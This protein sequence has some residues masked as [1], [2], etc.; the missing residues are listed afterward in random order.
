MNKKI[1]ILFLAVIMIFSLISCGGDDTLNDGTYS[2]QSSKGEKGDYAEVVL[3]IK[4]N[5]I[6]SVEFISYDSDGNVK[7]ENYGK[8]VGNEDFTE[9]AQIAYAGMMSY[10]EQINEKKELK[11]VEVVSGATIS[12]NQFTEAM[13][14]ALEEAKK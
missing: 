14:M 12:F 2:G 10:Q 4:D 7:D 5:Q 13:E 3:V 11:L 8:N 9:K 6:D 1:I